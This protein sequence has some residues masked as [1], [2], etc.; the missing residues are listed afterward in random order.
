LRILALLIALLVAAAPG[1][2]AQSPAVPAPE[3]PAAEAPAPPSA[4]PG[5]IPPP[6]EIVAGR[7]TFH[8]AGDVRLF[9]PHATARPE[10]LAARALQAD[11]AAA[12][13][14]TP[15]LDRLGP[16]GPPARGAIILAIVDY[17]TS[18]TIQ[19]QGYRLR[20]TPD[21]IAVLGNSPIG[22]FHGI[23]TLR[24]LVHIHGARLPSV[25]ITD[26]PDFLW[27]G[28][29]HD[30]SR[31]KVPTRETLFEMVDYLAAHK[32]NMFQLY[33]EHP[34][35]F[36]FNPAIAQNPDGLTAD[37][38]IA[39]QEYSRDR[40]VLFVPSLQAFG[41]MAGVLSLPEYRHLADV[42]LPGPWSELTWRERMSGATI[43][44][45]STEARALLERMFDEYIALFDAP[46]VNVCADETYDLGMGRNREL[47]MQL[48]RERLKE[49]PAEQ[50]AAMT[51]EELEKKIHH[52]GKGRL[53][54]N[55]ILFLHEL[56]RRHGKRMMFWGDIVKRHPELVKEIPRDVV[57]LNWGYSRNTDFES[58]G[59]FTSSGLE[60]FVCPGTN[61]WNRIL[62]GVENADLNI[63]RYAE[64][65]LRHGAVGL[66][67]TDWGD[68]GHVN[69]L[70][71]SLHGIALG[72]SVAWNQAATPGVAEF[73]R[74]WSRLVFN[75]EGDGA[76]AFRSVAST[77]GID[78]PS[79][80]ALYTP[81]A[82]ARFI[83]R[84][85]AEQAVRVTV[86]GF[87]GEMF[88]QEYLRAG[89]GKPWINRELILASQLTQLL[90]RKMML[91]HQ[92][93][94][95]DDREALRGELLSFAADVRLAQGR[96][97]TVWLERNR[98]AELNDVIN[99]LGRL[100]A[101]AE[102]LARTG[103]PIE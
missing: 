8:L 58:T 22:L 47:A 16:L 65:G 48:G 56:C 68:H 40:R 91:L 29:Y 44:V 101:E 89:R 85:S 74:R 39:I 98:Q 95:S 76:Q 38:I 102:A 71:G 25:A 53:Y 79:W 90:G 84:I 41:H 99:A 13:G 2:R 37:D 45:A 92:M 20:V 61:G 19:S 97:R 6:R 12:T 21:Q 54:I 14:T 86:D 34:F 4:D 80:I 43:D 32:I 23:Q 46:F 64:A 42:E 67:N 27:R 63:R 69:P 35:V 30:V 81:F 57:L 93:K 18:Y 59:L 50:V 78:T 3:A 33:I 11:I 88:F 1:C 77:V 28:F 10:L 60:T 51:S 15:P 7:G 49:L 31:G 82:E 52:L 66:L 87:F 62:N 72:A 5:L 96:L 73:D 24:Q 75:D 70:A 9:I 83:D 26:Q 36:R 17:P 100:S 103:Q 94:A 55:H